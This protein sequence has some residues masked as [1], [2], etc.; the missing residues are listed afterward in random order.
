M[1]TLPNGKNDRIPDVCHIFDKASIVDEYCPVCNDCLTTSYGTLENDAT[2]FP[3]A[4]DRAIENVC[5]VLSEKNGW[6]LSSS[7]LPEPKF[8]TKNGLSVSLQYEYTPK[9]KPTLG[10]EP[11]TATP[12]PACGMV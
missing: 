8:V 12:N 5:S 1:D 3:M 10:I 4:A 9:Y 7:F 2:V 6:R 11:R